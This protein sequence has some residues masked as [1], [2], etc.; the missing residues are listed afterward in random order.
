[1]ENPEKIIQKVDS[2]EVKAR[3][4]HVPEPKKPK[5][6]PTQEGSA[7][8]ADQNAD[9]KVSAN[10]PDSKANAHAP[11]K[12]PESAKASKPKKEKKP[13]ESKPKEPAQPKVATFPFSA[14]INPYGF[15][16]LGKAELRALG[17]TVCE[18]KGAKQKMPKEVAITVSAWNPEKKGLTIKV[19]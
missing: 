19:S 5:S 3:G 16:G 11:A 4:A 6:M 17:L 7:H 8:N 10:V 18:Q 9:A 15:I 2:D 14:T 12:E 13:K 1:M